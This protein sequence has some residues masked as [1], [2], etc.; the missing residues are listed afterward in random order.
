MLNTPSILVAV[1][2]F[3]I[4][5]LASRVLGQFL[6]RYKLPYIT[7]YLFTG[8]LA[9]PFALDMLPEGATTDLRFIDELSLAVIAFVAGSELYIKELRDRLRSIL[10]SV[11]MIVIGAMS[12][13]GT[14]IYLLT[15]TIPF[16]EGMSTTAKI[17]VAILGTTVLLALS[18]ASTIAVIQEARARGPFTKT[19]LS[20]AVVMDMVIIVLFAISTGVA[21]TLL[22]DTQF[23]IMFVIFLVLDLVLAVGLGVAVGKL[24]EFILSTSLQKSFKIGYVLGIGLLIFAFAYQL[25][26][27][28]LGIH[29][30]PLLQAMIAGFFITNFTRYRDEFEEILHD[31]SP[32]VY[33]AFFT[34]T[35]VALKLDILFATIGVALILFLIRVLGISVGTF[36]GSTIVKDDPRFRY[37]LGFGLVTQ[38]GI[39]LGLARETAIEFPQLGDEFATMIISVV[40]LNEIF[41]PILLKYVLNRVG[42]THMPE[43]HKPDEIR[44]ALI[45]GVEGQSL[46]L[47]RQLQ[48]HNWHV[49]VAD[50]NPS[51]VEAASPADVDGRYIPSID[52]QVFDELITTGTDAVIAMLDDDDANYNACELAYEKFGVRRLVVRLNDMRNTE[53]FNALGAVIVDPAT[54]IV[55]VIDHA[56][57]TPQSAALFMHQDPDFDIAQIT[58]TQ[59]E[60]D[61]ILLR[62]LRLPVDVL[63]LEISRDGHS[64][65]PNGSTMLSCGDDVTFVGKPA[66]LKEVTRRFGY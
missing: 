27:L 34:L 39:A 1:I 56:V 52:K 65:V 38:A 43:A 29:V 57:R 30:E 20:I 4:V 61:G 16:T 55:N 9:G 53:R 12:L 33:V 59:E 8:L 50:T 42:E 22:D 5:M 31:V 35:G 36:L 17:A 63:V 64:I 54:A 24:L 40:V 6:S 13:V 28:D 58:I 32:F 14:T 41:G 15:S 60:C 48:S 62:D 7:G 26:G 3:V 11:V 37:L 66:S 23:D 47:A 10:T 21:G 44:D 2:S 45:L 46:A 51:R 19:V 49:I 25:D 18:P